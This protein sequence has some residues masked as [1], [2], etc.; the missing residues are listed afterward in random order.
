MTFFCPSLFENTFM[1]KVIVA[2]YEYKK[3]INKIVQYSVEYRALSSTSTTVTD[4][5][6]PDLHVSRNKTAEKT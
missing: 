4:H 2:E 3:Q 1:L 5:P 6:D